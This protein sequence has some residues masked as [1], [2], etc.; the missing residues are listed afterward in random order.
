MKCMAYCFRTFQKKNAQSYTPS[1]QVQPW[2]PV[3]PCTNLMTFISPN[4]TLLK[5]ESQPYI[6]VVTSQLTQTVGTIPE[7]S[8]GTSRAQSASTVAYDIQRA[9]LSLTS[10]NASA[11]NLRFTMFPIKLD[12]NSLLFVTGRSEHYLPTGLK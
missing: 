12:E 2:L 9:H 4:A 1:S 3:M 5:C 10:S 11:H 7:W 6:L 8:R